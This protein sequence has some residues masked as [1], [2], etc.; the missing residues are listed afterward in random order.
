MLTRKNKP[1]KKAIIFL[2]AVV[3]L[4]GASPATQAQRKKALTSTEANLLLQKLE[5]N[6]DISYYKKKD[7]SNQLTEKEGVGT[8][9]RDRKKDYVHEQVQIAQADGNSMRSEGFLRYCEAKERFEFV[10]IDDSG[11]TI[12]LLVGQWHPD[13]NTLSFKPVKG[14]EQWGSTTD[15][16]LNLQCHYVFKEDGTF[17]KLMRIVDENGNYIITDQYHY[18]VADVAKL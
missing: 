5:G 18:K 1:M 9:S 8:N 3:L 17:I 10:Q 6:W 11:K 4:A 2:L 13:Y 12:L 15:R 14:F 7:G 16:N